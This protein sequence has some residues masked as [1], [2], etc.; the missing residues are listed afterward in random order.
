[1][2]TWAESELGCCPL[3]DARLTRRL[4][5]L[6]EAFVAHPGA[7]IP[8]ATGSRKA[9]KAAY[10]FLDN[11]RVGGGALIEAHRHETRYRVAAHEVVLA[12]QDTTSLDF[13]SHPQ[14]AGL[15]ILSDPHHRGLFLHTTLLVSPRRVPLGVLHQQTWTRLP[16]EA[17]KRHRRKARPLRQ[18]ES[19]KWVAGLKETA[20]FA[21]SVPGSRVVMVGDREADLYDL[22]RRADRFGQPLLIR[23]AWDRC[24][25][26]PQKHLFE[27]VRAQPPAGTF[28]VTLPRQPGRPPREAVLAVRFTPVR[29]RPPKHR[30]GTFWPTLPAWAVL[31]REEAPPEGARPVEWLL[32]TTVPVGSPEEARERVEW[33][34]CRWVIEE[35]H[36]VLKSGCRTEDRQLRRVERLE[37]CLALDG[38]VAWRL[39][40]LTHEGR[41]RPQDP[42]TRVLSPREWPVLHAVTHPGTPL[43]PAPPTLREALR[44]MAQLGGFLGR[45]G[46]GEPGPMTLW[47]G[48][49]RFLDILAGYQLSGPPPPL[50]GN[51]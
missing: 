45:E 46:D 23:A 20:R 39:L 13:T 36:K 9:A 43:P 37:R 18:K 26:H 51:D 14:T 32:L 21:R 4:V 5:K 50:V 41:T 1:M 34:S 11:G 12:V 40:F 47:R 6:A 33:Y 10:R 30:K 31:A 2:K 28:T 7:L 49:R 8:Q 38:I 19:H 44:W 24:V 3:G 27:C 42:C 35:Y 17:G 25:D 16:E 48:Y 15:G 29:L 22:F